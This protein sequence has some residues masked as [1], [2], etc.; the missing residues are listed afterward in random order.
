MSSLPIVPAHDLSPKRCA[1]IG[2]D[3]PDL[4]IPLELVDV[5]D[6]M[7]DVDFKVFAGPANDPKGRVAALRVP[8]GGKLSRKQIDDYTKFVGIYGA[9]GLAYIKVN[10]LAKGRE[11]LQS[12]IVKFLPDATVDGSCWSA[13]ARSMATSCSSVPTKPRSSTKRWARCASSS[14]T[15]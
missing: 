10:E 2:F 7:Q 13:L 15:T 4:R 12:P 5:A 3:K 8:G 11:G 6:L 14:V 9:K 1:V